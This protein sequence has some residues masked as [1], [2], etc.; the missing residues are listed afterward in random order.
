MTSHPAPAEAQHAL[1]PGCPDPGGPR[2]DLAAGPPH[3]L[4]HD[5]GG[6]HDALGEQP[7]AARQDGRLLQRDTQGA[8]AGAGGEARRVRQVTSCPTMAPETSRAR[9]CTATLTIHPSCQA[10]P[11]ASRP[12]L[13]G[14]APASGLRTAPPPDYCWTRFLPA[15][16]LSEKTPQPPCPTCSVFPLA[17]NTPTHSQCFT[18]H[19]LPLSFSVT[20]PVPSSELTS[21]CPCH[22]WQSG[23]PPGGSRARKRWG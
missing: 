3:L 16:V 21:A 18:V 17:V 12:A 5:V 11:L 13:P 15:G 1:S 14:G 6:L 23:K 8:P 22:T 10:G 19:A 4:P 9:K 2:R 7:V 20:L